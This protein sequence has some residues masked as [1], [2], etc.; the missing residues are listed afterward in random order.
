[1]DFFH[2]KSS[3][4]GQCSW[5]EW[6]WFWSDFSGTT[7]SARPKWCFLE[8]EH[9]KKKSLFQILH[10]ESFIVTH[11]GQFQWWNFVRDGKII[12]ILGSSTSKNCCFS[13]KRLQNHA[14]PLLVATDGFETHHLRCSLVWEWGIV[15][16]VWYGGFLSHVG[17]LP[18]T[19]YP[20]VN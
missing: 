12:Q 6:W 15:P 11:P 16:M 7:C 14:K 5:G 1:M 13:S 2:F 20:L 3:I 18:S 19:G 10:V 17:T 9:I 8:R 4:L